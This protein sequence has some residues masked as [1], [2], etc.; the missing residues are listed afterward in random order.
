MAWNTE[1]FRSRIKATSDCASTHRSRRA[2]S[3]NRPISLAASSI[4]PGS[5]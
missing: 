4:S 1:V 3:E 2:V 5:C